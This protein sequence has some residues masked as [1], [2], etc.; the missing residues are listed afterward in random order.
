MVA[1]TEAEEVTEVFRAYGLTPEECR[2]V[3]DALRARPEARVDFMMRFELAY[4]RYLPTTRI[5]KLPGTISGLGIAPPGAE[6]FGA[7]KRAPAR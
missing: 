6:G 3:V 7:E 1:E 2:P 4:A 5:S